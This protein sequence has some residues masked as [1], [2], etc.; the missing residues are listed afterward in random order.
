MTMAELLT[1]IVSAIAT[2]IAWISLRK[3]NR[4][5]RKQLE[6]QAKQEE[7][8]KPERPSAAPVDL[9]VTLCASDEWCSER[10]RASGRDHQMAANARRTTA[11]R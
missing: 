1:I 10:G 9:T 8:A 6:L 7:L 4:F 2:F 3:T 5:E 11:C